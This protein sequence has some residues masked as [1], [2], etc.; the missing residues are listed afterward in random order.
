MSSGAPSCVFYLNACA[1]VHALV[2]AG[3]PKVYN[4]FV[5]R[6]QPTHSFFCPSRFLFFISYSSCARP[7]RCP[8]GT[9]VWLWLAICYGVKFICKTFLHLYDVDP[10]PDNGG[11][12]LFVTIRPIRGSPETFNG[13]A[14]KVGNA[15]PPDKGLSTKRIVIVVYKDNRP[16]EL[17]LN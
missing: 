1:C 11:L 4:F 12:S 10:C 13:C 2:H 14:Y 3:A 8:G 7:L 17:H 9:T 16:A 6:Y 15:P 5:S